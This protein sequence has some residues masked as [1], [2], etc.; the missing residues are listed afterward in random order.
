MLDRAGHLFGAVEREP[1]DLAEVRALAG[2]LEVEP[3][4][5]G[6]VLVGAGRDGELALLVVPV[7]DVL[8]IASQRWTPCYAVSVNRIGCVSVVRSVPDDEVLVAVV[9]YRWE[10]TVGIVFGECRSLVLV[11]IGLE[12]DGLVGQAKL[13]EDESNL[14]TIKHTAISVLFVLVRRAIP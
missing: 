10:A 8:E 5:L 14:P 4:E 12:E 9:D 6:V 3:L 1:A 2:C 13:L 7:D 11:L